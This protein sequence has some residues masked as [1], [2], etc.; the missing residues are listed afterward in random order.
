MSTVHGDNMPRP[1]TSSVKILCILDIEMSIKLTK[2]KAN[3]VQNKIMKEISAAAFYYKV[4]I[5]YHIYSIMQV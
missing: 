4:L 3:L 5:L 2:F 1:E